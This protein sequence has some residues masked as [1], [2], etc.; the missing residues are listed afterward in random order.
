MIDCTKVHKN[1]TIIAYDGNNFIK[2]GMMVGQ[3]QTT[4]QTCINYL[5]IYPD[6]DIEAIIDTHESNVELIEPGL[7]DYLRDYH[8]EDEPA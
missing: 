5:K 2:K 8:K 1:I 7:F 6:H 3:S 4:N